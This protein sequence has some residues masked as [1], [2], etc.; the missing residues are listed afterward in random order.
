MNHNDRTA[1]IMEGGAMR[2]MFTCGILDVWMENGIQF[3]AAA[4]ISAGA[5]FGCNFKS[6]QIGRALRYNKKYAGDPRYCSFRSLIRT[7]DLYGV[8]FC[9]EELPLRL[10]VFDQETF[11]NNPMPFFIGATDVNTGETLYH[12]CT[13][14]GEEDLT[15]MRAS[16]SMPM[17]SRPVTVDGHTLLDGGISD[18]IPFSYMESLGYYHNVVILTQPSDYVKKPFR[19]MA[20]A[21]I[22]LKKYPELISAMKKR[23]DLY[24]AQTAAIRKR[25][26]DGKYLVLCPPVSLGISRTEKNPDELER[27]YR[28]GRSEAEKRMNEVRAFLNACDHQKTDRRG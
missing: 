12:R 14:G 10:D 6:Q 25:E 17:V 28:I 18:P 23:H 20:L 2:G 16:A 15:W 4:G 9:Y 21:K 5:V 11:K 27:V 13:D 1:L 7:G 22:M 8:R 24:N 3:D 19:A 26:E